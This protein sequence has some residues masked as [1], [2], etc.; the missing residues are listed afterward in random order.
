MRLRKLNFHIFEDTVND[1]ATALG[2]TT[3]EKFGGKEDGFIRTFRVDGPV[4]VRHGEFVVAKDFGQEIFVFTNI[5]TMPWQ[6]LGRTV[7]M[8]PESTVFFDKQGEMRMIKEFS[9]GSQ[10]TFQFFGS[11][12]SDFFSDT[13]LGTILVL[14][15]LVLGGFGW[16]GIGR[17]RLGLFRRICNWLVFLDFCG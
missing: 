16:S 9:G 3:A 4:P 8:I 5:K 7:S 2:I 13:D 14:F 15:N 1:S 10:V 6:E 11:Q 17:F 12:V